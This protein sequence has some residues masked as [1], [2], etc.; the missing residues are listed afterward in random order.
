MVKKIMENDKVKFKTVYRAQ[1][2]Y[3]QNDNNYVI[4]LTKFKNSDD[5]VFREILQW[6]EKNV[7]G[8]YSV[9]LNENTNYYLTIRIWNEESRA[10]FYEKYSE[11]IQGVL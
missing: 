9:A 2:N 5:S 3:L 10:K 7:K 11:Y 4:Y 1:E 8:S 6:C